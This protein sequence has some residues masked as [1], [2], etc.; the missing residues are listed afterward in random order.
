MGFR[1][2][3]HNN[4]T[5]ISLKN[6]F[7]KIEPAQISI[8]AKSGSGKG[9]HGES[10]AEL[11]HD[12]GYLI[13]VL[14]D[15]KN[16]I[17][18]GFAQFKPEE[19][20]H[21]N[22]L[23][24]Q[25][26]VP[27][28]KKVKL[29]HPFTFSIPKNKYLPDINFYTL[30]LKELRREEWSMIAESVYDSDT[31]KLLMDSSNSIGKEDELYSFLHYIQQ[32]VKGKKEK[33]EM[34]IDP[35][36]FDL[37]VT[38]GTLKSLQ[39]VSNY[40]KI[41]K[42]DW[43]LSSENCPLNLDMKSILQDQE[44]YHVFISKWIS[45]KKLSEFLVLA[46]LNKIIR[47]RDYIKHP[48]CIVIPEVKFLTPFK[49]KEAYKEFLASGIKDA[50]S[51]VRSI[52]K[53]FS[54]IIDAQTFSSVDREVRGSSTDIFFGENSSPDDLEEIA[55]AMRYKRSILEQ[56]SKMENRNS[57]LLKGY[58]TFGAWKG[59]FP[60][61]MHCEPSYNFFSIYARYKKDSM[62]MYG[63]TIDMMKKR[64]E[65]DRERVNKIR[66]LREKEIQ[67]EEQKLVQEKQGREVKEVK[68]IKEKLKKVTSEKKEEI[69]KRAY[70]LKQQG[71]SNRKIALNIGISDVTAGDYI[72]K[73]EKKIGKSKD[74]SVEEIIKP[75]DLDFEED[76]LESDE[77]LENDAQI[78]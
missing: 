51:T 48:I 35:D 20:Y 3:S 14:C 71:L 38:S 10:L 33:K 55:K 15:P 53:G 47:N 34:H 39:D 62:R 64:I 25:G 13:I 68:I 76:F 16:E 40:F 52:G 11:F 77:N 69:M 66:K 63:N 73:Y 22:E 32:K 12:N 44:S 74:E 54:S 49:P 7:G 43:F 56:L 27:K 58:E 42:N 29:Y 17:E 4:Y 6:E 26:K 59:F 8:Y 70:E 67:E 30:P 5:F 19:K 9:L 21:L 31:I 23:R 50:L 45:D 24:K 78:I 61:H 2:I 37:Q 36:N 1:V 75:D 60:S 28:E 41:F 46:L 57:Y 65:N 18:Y 72:K